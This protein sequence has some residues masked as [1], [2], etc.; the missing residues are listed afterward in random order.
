M[1]KYKITGHSMEPLLKNGDKIIATGLFYL[2]Q[3]PKI[4][5]IV[6]FKDSKGKVFIKRIEKINKG[7]YFMLGENKK[8]SFDSRK[9][10]EIVRNQILGKFIYKI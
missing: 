10:G 7:K 9:F 6:V 4:N 2:F 5:D 1:A 8:D 3:S